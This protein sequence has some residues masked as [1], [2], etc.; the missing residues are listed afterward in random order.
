MRNH[1]YF[2]KSIKPAQVR[3]YLARNNWRL[4]DY[5]QNQ[6][7]KFK[8]INDPTFILF[9]PTKVEA[10]DYIIALSKVIETISF[11]ENA[12][13]DDVLKRIIS[14]SQ[15]ILSFRFM[16]ALADQASLPL[17]FAIEAMK[18]IQDSLIFAACSEVQPPQPF[19]SRK[20][21]SA[22]SLLESSRFGQTQPGSFI[23]NVEIPLEGEAVTGDGVETVPP[24][25]R[26]VSTRLLRGISNAQSLAY[27]NIPLDEED[28][29]IGLNANL[30]DSLYG[31]FSEDAGLEVEI[32]SN[33]SRN[34]P[35]TDTSLNSKVIVD[36]LTFDSIKR[37][38][39]TLRSRPGAINVNIIATVAGLSRED[40]NIDNDEEDT[41]DSLRNVILKPENLD[42]FPCRSFKV[43]LNSHDYDSACDAHK[44]KQKINVTGRLEKIGRFW[45]LTNYDTF[46]IVPN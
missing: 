17:S 46:R 10:S 3:S 32:S 35:Q 25:L 34:F 41:D 30:A 13:F 18:N 5:N 14:P 20:L 12:S 36:E 19:Y 39:S 38:G 42:N 40:F 23:V 16:G 15:D 7:L 8:N 37:I 45:T 29:K 11:F 2:L 33:W 24:I 44:L 43:S 21:N 27:D 28:Y 22:I 31:L 6:V 1:L 26:R 4:E 9:V